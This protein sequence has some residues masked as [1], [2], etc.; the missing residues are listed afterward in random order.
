MREIDLGGG[1]PSISPDWFLAHGLGND[2]LVFHES[3]SGAEGWPGTPEAIAA[4]CHRWKGVGSDGIVVRLREPGG[5]L[6]LNPVRSRAFNPDGGEFERSGNGIRVLAAS[7][8]FSGEVDAEPFPLV[9]GTG[10]VV[11]QVL[12][13]LPGGRYDVQVDMGRA[14]L[15]APSV[16]LDATAL[17]PHGALPLE[18]DGRWS[19]PFTHVSMG[20][21]HCVVFPRALSFPVDLTGKL[22]E[23]LGPAITSHPA[24]TQGVNVQLVEI[25]GP[26][27]LRIGIWERGVGRTTASGT[28]A[29]AAAVAAVVRGYVLPGEITVSM[30]G[31]DFQIGVTAD[32][33]VELRGP[34]QVVSTGRLAPGFVEALRAL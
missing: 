18:V 17:D 28:S 9:F 26:A 21:P 27:H 5:E 16:A 19:V 7:L 32:L 8:A 34:V 11:C 13:V 33:G 4:V 15:D 6:S 12:G 14:R 2:Y 24:F 1:I 10:E 23:K 31:G 29:C 3:H 30:E 22:L 20:N 25:T